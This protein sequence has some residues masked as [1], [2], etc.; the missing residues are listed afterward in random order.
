MKHCEDI[1][2][3]QVLE[4]LEDVWLRSMCRTTK[5]QKPV[6]E[7]RPLWSLWW[8]GESLNSMVPLFSGPC[9][10]VCPFLRAYECSNG[11]SSYVPHAK[12]ESTPLNWLVSHSIS[13][14]FTKNMVAD[15]FASCH[16][17]QKSVYATHEAC[18][19]SI[20]HP[21]FSSLQLSFPQHTKSF[22]ISRSPSAAASSQP[23]L[24]TILHTSPP[25]HALHHDPVSQFRVQV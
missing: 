18:H 12:N 4:R 14:T 5:D 2:S 11:V 22:P 13:S 25:L 7:P 15:Q 17:W 19:F 8:L 23:P 1:T 6:T 9:V 16:C 21:D 3:C 20:S 10:S 24:Q